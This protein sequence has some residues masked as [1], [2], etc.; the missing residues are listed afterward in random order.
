MKDTDTKPCWLYV[1]G[2]VTSYNDPLSKMQSKDIR[3]KEKAINTCLTSMLVDDNYPDTLMIQTIKY[4]NP[5]E[6][7]SIKKSLLL[8]W[9]VIEKKNK[10]KPTELKSEFLLVCNSIRKDLTHP[11]EYVRG[12]VLR[13]V[14]KLPY[15]DLFES[16]RSVIFENLSHK[17]SY[18]RKNAL[19]CVVSII[20]NF[21]VDSLPDNIVETLK[22]LIEKDSD[23]CTRRNAYVALAEVD[24]DESLNVTKSILSNS[25]VNELGDMFILAIVRNLKVLIKNFSNLKEKGAIIKMLIELSNHKS[26][27]VLFE[28]ACALVAVSSNTSIIRNA[29]TILSNL[30]VE[31]NDNNLLLII[32]KKLVDLKDKYKAVLEENIVSLVVIINQNLT[33]NLRKLLLG[34]V[35]DLITESNIA[36]VFNLFTKQYNKLKAISDSSNT[37]LVDFRFSIIDCFYNNVK[38]YPVISKQFV[39]YLLDKIL[40]FDSNSAYIEDQSSM[41]KE[42]F[43]IYK[44][45]CHDMLSK[46]ILSFEDISDPTIMLTTLYVFRQYIENEPSLLGQVF[47]LLVKNLGELK[48]EL[49]ESFDS[50]KEGEQSSSNTSRKTITKTVVAEDGTYRTQTTYIN[51]DQSKKE[52]FFLRECLLNS[53]F[54][55]ASTLVACI[56]KIYFLLYESL[57]EKDDSGRDLNNYFLS[58]IN[59]VCAIIKMNSYKVYKDS[60]NL[61]R[62]NMCLEILLENDYQKFLKWSRESKDIYINSIVVEK[63][64]NQVTQKTLKKNAVGD[65]INFRYVVPYDSNNIG[66]ID[67]ES[68]DAIDE[69]II[70][71]SLL[72]NSAETGSQKNFV[73]T[74][75]GLEDSLQVDATFEIFPFDIVVEFNIKNRTKQDLQNISI[76]LYAPTNLEIIE[77]APSV[78]LAAGEQV[79]VKSCIKISSTCNSFIFGE[80]SYSNYRGTVNSINLSGVFINLLN[81][82]AAPCTESNFRKC[83]INYNWEH[84]II[85]I[86]KL[87]QFSSLIEFISSNLNLKLVYPSDLTHIDEESGFLVANL[88]TKSKLEEEAL[89]NISV[90]K[91]QDKRIVGTVVIRSKVKEFATFLGERI[92]SLVK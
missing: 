29:I 19:A 58:T 28:I 23:L 50:V 77:K 17:H 39:Q 15:Y 37:S 27:A 10:Q 78:T 21:G 33:Q 30:L 48:F 18:V 57:N 5:C 16:V 87:T 22:D 64:T 2:Q 12:R 6:D 92:K 70:L 52:K 31:V 82:Y 45:D 1:D 90:E 91:N 44:D 49:I 76:D 34:I 71:E 62:I 74:L 69:N 26:H 43:Y 65:F 55:F 73:V 8:F 51:S 63:P 68:D 42:L 72:N 66:F 14:S 9:E 46:L 38:K 61:Q 35:S 59:I 86:S 80:I 60:N 89:V 75:T 88:F 84:K 13:L 81:T 4:V 24:I 11:N 7:L 41:I 83:W 36:S 20:K 85:L 56:T 32:I 40:S 53:N 47:D 79:K 25:E 67:E 54:F 3:D